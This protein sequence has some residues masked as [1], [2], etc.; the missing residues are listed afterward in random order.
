MASEQ[1]PGIVEAAI[2]AAAG[3]GVGLTVFKPKSWQEALISFFGSFSA[4]IFLGPWA[5]EMFGGGS[6]AALS[7]AGFG[8]GV[9][10]LAIA[11][12]AIRTAQDFIRKRLGLPVNGGGNDASS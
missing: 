1:I 12:W 10:F 8:V 5:G 4:A 9:C 7:A 2:P 11:P 6:P 3:A